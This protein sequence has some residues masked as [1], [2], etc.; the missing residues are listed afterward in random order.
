MPSIIVDNLTLLTKRTITITWRWWQCRGRKP[1]SISLIPKYLTRNISNVFI[2]YWNCWF[3]VEQR[4]AVTSRT[5]RTWSWW[6]MSPP[7]PRP[8]PRRPYCTNHTRP[9]S[10]YIGFLWN[11]VSSK[12]IST[13]R[14]YYTNVQ[15][16]IYFLLYLTKQ[17]SYNQFLHHKQNH[18]K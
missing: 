18:Y 2:L 12:Y 16:L 7:R 4:G 15:I 17:H 14:N 1:L 8:P 10:I 3:A 13:Y 5:R 9:V 11:E 6:M